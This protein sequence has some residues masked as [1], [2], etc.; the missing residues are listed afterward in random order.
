MLRGTLIGVFFEQEHDNIDECWF[1]RRILGL[2]EKW[3]EN[4][5]IH[6]YRTAQ[7]AQENYE[8]RRR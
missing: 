8:T 2:Q 1:A 4:L 3:G 7:A 5:G 6:D